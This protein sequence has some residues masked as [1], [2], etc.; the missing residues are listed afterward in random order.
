M[1]YLYLNGAN[2]EKE[3]PMARN[4]K[5]LP[6]VPVVRVPGHAKK[7]VVK[8]TGKKAVLVPITL[9]DNVHK[10]VEQQKN[11]GK[12]IVV[13]A[14]EDYCGDWDDKEKGVWAINGRSF[15]TMYQNDS[16]KISGWGVPTEKAPAK[17]PNVIISGVDLPTIK[18]IAEEF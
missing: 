6:C 1:L 2:K 10:V 14:N 11:D 12:V 3:L 7:I 15:L 5:P 4:G 9:R 16:Q 17:L 13:D 8:D 18:R